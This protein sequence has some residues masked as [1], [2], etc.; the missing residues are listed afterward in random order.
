MVEDNINNFIPPNQY[1]ENL[2]KFKSQ[3]PPILD[4]FKKYYVFFYKNPEYK[5]YENSFQNVKA[6]LDNINLQLISLSK[7]VEN[8]TDNLNS[9]LVVVNKL[10]EKERVKNKLLKKKLGIIEHQTH[11]SS[12]MIND[13]KKIYSLGY[14]RNWGLLTS[15][16]IVG[17]TIKLVFNKKNNPVSFA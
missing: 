15:I 3:L 7:S 4:E 9:K 2:N 17:I 8:S 14:I 6:N 16:I 5:E 10:I 12:E 11:A 13:F 1:L